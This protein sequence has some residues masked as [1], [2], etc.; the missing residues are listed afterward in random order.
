MLLWLCVA[1]LALAGCEQISVSDR[2]QV[3]NIETIRALTP[4]PTSSPLPSA[5][6]TITP[7]LTPTAGPSA[8]PTLTPLPPTPTPDPA[9]SG[10]SFCTQAAGGQSG[11][12][13]AR[14]SAV[15]ASGFPAYDRIV[16]TFEPAPDSP[17]IHALA[18]CLN[19]SD[20]LALSG[21]P[22][23]PG[24]TTLQ[25]DLAD[26]IVD[27]ALRTTALTQTL[28]FSETRAVRGVA[29]R[30]DTA[31]AN[32]A[33][34][35]MSLDEPTVFRLS[36]NERPAQLIVD[37]ARNSPLVA[38]SDTL[39]TVA[40]GGMASLD[41]PLYF[42]FDGD[43]W[44]TT[45]AARSPDDAL[46]PVANG[47]E[48]LTESPETETALAMS[49]DGATLAFCR[50][51]SAADPAEANLAVPSRL[52]LMKADG[53]DARPVQQEGVNCADPTFSPDGSSV[54]FS[55]DE[56]G[57]TPPQRSLWV[58]TVA[59]GLPQRVVGGDEWSSFAPQWIEG[60]NLVYSALA[61]DGR[62]TLFLVSDG[63]IADIGAALALADDGSVRYRSFG[64]PLAAPDGSGLAV[65]AFRADSTGVDLLIL[66]AD[67]SLVETIGAPLTARPVPQ[68]TA[69]TAASAT[70]TAR[71]TAT[72]SST[73]TLTVT[74]GTATPAATPTL[75]PIPTTT[76]Q[77]ATSG[78]APYWSRPLTWSADGQLFYLTTN[79]ASSLVQDYQ[80][81][82]WAGPRR[83]DLVA[84]G[85]TTAA[86]GSATAV[87]DG[88]AYVISAQ[89]LPGE[90][91]AQ[92]ADLRSPAEIWYWNVSSGVRGELLT[93]ARG[94]AA[95]TR[96]SMFDNR[97]C[98]AAAIP[99]LR[100]FFRGGKWRQCA[101][102]ECAYR[103]VVAWPRSVQAVCHQRGYN[104]C[105]GGR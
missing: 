101:Q 31:A 40:G 37:V 79:C 59:E 62:S 71:A 65:E 28:T 83:S 64:R 92:N 18:R 4:S 44:R 49:A 55:V 63:V 17:P 93:A 2:E 74:I 6:P 29:M 91:G 75:T 96:G 16:F 61:Q 69:T 58:V 34:L 81:Y 77:A 88:L 104:S 33:S 50:A 90:R 21:E 97:R 105:C 12:F 57:V 68:V 89:A 24:S 10:F 52:W 99:Q 1:L 78:V 94:V 27:D 9:L 82:R 38:A 85:Q 23:A 25:L 51:D 42:L 70:R 30:Y 39:A 95:L 87:G 15:T 46:S 26:W 67:G 48:R 98:A 36:I 66:D 102:T 47:A 14:L 8:T 76:P 20:F 13:S 45:V 11:R 35:L 43:I 103:P 19:E 56:T 32:G 80:L 3:A 72:V 7:T 60:D 100:I 73:A 41:T 53:S 22:V 84:T 86:L 5:T 54:A